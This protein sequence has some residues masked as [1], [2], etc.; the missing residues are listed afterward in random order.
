[1]RT[2][3]FVQLCIMMFLQFFLW[4]AWY[5]TMGGFM[6]NV[7][8]KPTDVGWAYSVGPIAGMISPFF[9]GMIADRFFATERVLGAMHILGGLAMFA[10]IAVMGTAENTLA[11][12]VFSIGGAELFS[13]SIPNLS[14]VASSPLIINL[15]FFAHMLCYYPTL[16]LTNTLAMHNMTNSEKQFP[17][18]R[19]FGTLGWIAAGFFISWQAWDTMINPFYV[20]A[21]TSI[22]LGVF[23]FTLPHTPPPSKGKEVS[24]AEILG[25]DAFKLLAHFPFLV[26]MFCSFL[27][28][29]PLAFYYQLT[30][31]FI[32]G[33]YYGETLQFVGGRGIPSPAAVMSLGQVSE[34]LFML[35]IPLFFRQL[36]VKWMLFVGMAAWVIRYALFALGADAGVVWML[37]TGVV[38]HGI[39]YD[40]FFV[41][42]QIYTD[43]TAPS[44]LRGQAQGMLVLFTLGLGMLI[45]AQVCGYVEAAFTEQVPGGAFYQSNAAA[46]AKY[47]DEEVLKIENL[48]EKDKPKL[49]FSKE[50]A[51]QLQ[52]VRDAFVAVAVEEESSDTLAPI[53]KEIKVAIEKLGNTEDE[54]K[55]EAVQKEIDA[56]Q[57]KQMEALNDLAMK[58]ALSQADGELSS[59]G[60]RL[61]ALELLLGYEEDQTAKGSPI[62]YWKWIWLL[63]T[64][65]AMFVAL[66]FSVTFFDKVDVEDED[67]AEPQP[68]DEEIK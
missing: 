46:V 5:V 9:V 40:F 21:F 12:F 59:N 17:F 25:L 30:F 8:F 39:C 37:I 7:G 35:L 13:F 52:K 44:H 16:S 42:G 49:L 27:I 1:M 53:R 20:A 66:L 33:G 31:K 14:F 32:A 3:V 36:G 57:G 56:L 18:I 6:G 24:A 11:P 60:Q 4:G 19:V 23:S 63:P 45:G 62:V 67:A 43:K 47:V 2:T 65:F 10:A 26:F 29:I 34:V 15:L 54:A 58:Q 51:E 61:L 41:T 68:T 28:C 55:Q 50:E 64:G 48:E 22:L 38:L